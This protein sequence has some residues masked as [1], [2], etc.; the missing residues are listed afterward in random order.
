MELGGRSWTFWKILDLEIDIN[1]FGGSSETLELQ[2]DVTI[3]TNLHENEMLMR[4]R[5]TC[6]NF[7][8]YEIFYKPLVHF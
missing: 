7:S 8:I 1:G 3:Q 2:E 4:K 5:L 6:Y